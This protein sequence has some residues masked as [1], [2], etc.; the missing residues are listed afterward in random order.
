ML[1]QAGWLPVVI[2]MRVVWLEGGVMGSR[3]AEG[4]G[5]C[6]PKTAPKAESKGW[7]GPKAKV[8]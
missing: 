6:G 8:G 3:L 5:W 4:K 7:C 2:E 1:P